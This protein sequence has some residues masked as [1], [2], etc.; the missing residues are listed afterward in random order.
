[1]SVLALLGVVVLLS[2]VGYQ[3]SEWWEFRD[4]DKDR[5]YAY[6]DN[7][8]FGDHVEPRKRPVYL[9]QGWTASQSLWFY[10]TTQG[11]DLIPYDFFFALE[12][13][14]GGQSKEGALFSS[15]EN[16]NHY[17]Y[18]VRGKTAANPDALP[19]G[20]VKDRYRGKDY[21][22]FTC[23]ACHTGQI[24]YRGQAIRIDG[25][26]AMADMYNF[27]GEMARDLAVAADSKTN[28]AGHARFIANVLKRG[29]YRNAAEVERDLDKYAIRV[30]AYY[31]INYSNTKYGYA[32]LD[33][34]GRIYNQV[35]GYVLN[36]DN[37]TDALN[38]L[39]SEGKIT[40]SDLQDSHINEL[41]KSLRAKVSGGGILKAADRD[42]FYSAL[43]RYSEF[44][45]TPSNPY[46]HLRAVIEIRNQIFVKPDAPVSYPFLW[47]IPQHDYV[48]WN[49]IASNAGLGPLGRNT[50]E[51][52]GVFGTMD[53]FES[54]HWTIS[55]VFSGQGLTNSHPID[56]ASSVRVHN[57]ALIEQQ[58]GTLQAPAW[59]EDIFGKINFSDTKS[60]LPN[61]LHK[62]L[63]QH[64]KVLFNQLCAQCHENIDPKA[65]DRR[66]VAHMSAVDNVK[67]DPWMARN[68]ADD[69]GYSGILRNQTATLGP[70]KVLLDKKAPV[71]GLLTTAVTGVIATPDPDKWFVTRFIQW[72][73]DVIFALRSNN[74]PGT[75]KSGDYIADTTADPVASLRAYK[76]RAL[77]GIW[78]TAPYLHNGSV[79][80]LYDLLLPASPERGDPAGT[81][82]R[83]TTFTVGSREF[84]KCRV[85]FIYKTSL[86]KP[87]VAPV[88]QLDPCGDPE[89]TTH[90]YGDP[91]FGCGDALIGYKG[92]LFVTSAPANSN[93]G[94]E[95]GTRIEA[96][97]ARGHVLKNPDG[98]SKM[99]PM[100]KQDRLDLLEYLKS[101]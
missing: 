75:L 95:Y 101:L 26:P 52:L 96:V 79:P 81:E 35:L 92:C 34:F 44:G 97:D 62:P 78:A 82:Y 66:I 59:P 5:G 60:M 28:A 99:V 2:Y 45:A 54:N 10:N 71:A 30:N 88:G 56:F 13:A 9:D 39:L 64:G 29:N 38:E 33:A 18:L 32:R 61:G 49:G 87:A 3:I 7:D 50:G 1:M 91:Q 40:T 4:N 12:R 31:V 42:E 53:W 8:I 22:G 57:L 46:P 65:E 25:A 83:P 67:T 69:V 68:G 58:L 80:T 11:S 41:L 37:I 36:V 48:Q 15:P 73:Y 70:G 100:S 72:A 85:G 19:I 89:D 86:A 63:A 23:S 76:G 93:A 98:S 16:I 24:N 77:D 14:A 51:V 84:D 55:G 74:I 43:S 17:R 20:I 27:I 90:G 94:H 21:M 6:V 47:D